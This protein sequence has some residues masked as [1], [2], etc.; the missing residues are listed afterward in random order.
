MIRRLSIA[1]TLP[2]ALAACG[3][4]L[5]ATLTPSVLS[6]DTV[7]SLRT[8]CSR[9][10]PLIALARGQNMMPAAR[11]IAD[12]VG[13]Y[14]DALMA[15][16]IPPTTDGNTAAWLPTNIAGLGQALGITLR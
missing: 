14:C 16:Q 10:A 4:N 13:P 6:P 5:A 9:G 8:W 12:V 2:L 11:E 15:G 1:C 7:A 3:G